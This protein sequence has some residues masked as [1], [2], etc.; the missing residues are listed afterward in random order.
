MDA[1]RLTKVTKKTV[2]ATIRDSPVYVRATLVKVQGKSEFLYTRS[3]INV[4]PIKESSADIQFRTQFKVIGRSM[5]TP[6]CPCCCPA[7]F[8][9]SLF[10]LRFH[11]RQENLGAPI[12]MLL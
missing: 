6:H 2:M 3:P 4:S 11:S 7:M 8:S 1:Y 12:K 9:A 5:V 10:S